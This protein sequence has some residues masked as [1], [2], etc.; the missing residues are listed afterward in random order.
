M[1]KLDWQ[2]AGNNTEYQQT[3]EYRGLVIRAMH[4]P[5]PSNP[6]TDDDGHW[7]MLTLYDRS[8]TNYRLGSGAWNPIA[9][10]FIDYNVVLFQK[11][12]AKALDADPVEAW[13]A[14]HGDEELEEE[15]PKWFTHIELLRDCFAEAWDGLSYRQQLEAAETLLGLIGIPAAH[16]RSIG[17]CQG[18][19]TDL[20][21]V[22]PPER[23]KELMGAHYQQELVQR[24]KAELTP[25]ERFDPTK[26]DAAIEKRVADIWLKEQF[27]PQR[28]L[29]SAWAW[30]N[31][32][33]WQLETH[34]GE[35][36]EASCWGYFGDHDDSELEE[37]AMSEADALIAEI[38]RNATERLKQMIRAKA[39]L[40]V[41]QQVLAEIR[42]IGDDAGHDD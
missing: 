27:E 5:H 42:R 36:L 38:E 18:D 22:A 1:T 19:V 26:I 13:R 33:G 14:Y 20:L 7:P 8:L 30:G 2:D 29:F 24:A 41:R 25:E 15:P 6:F 35:E 9:E 40:H 23:I 21:I 17:Y 28:D 16:L 12:I 37:A 39:P 10:H 3:A 32:W 31:T 4:D 34:S 11:Q